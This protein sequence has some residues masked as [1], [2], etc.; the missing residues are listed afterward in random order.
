MTPR[1][2]LTPKARAALLERQGN[3]CACC[4]DPLAL[5]KAQ[6][7]HMAPLWA[8]ADNG[9]DN[10]QLLCGGCHARKTRAE[11]AARGKTKRLENARL[12][13]RKVAASKMQS[14]GFD[15]RLRRL[16]SGKVEVR[17]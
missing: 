12:N 9:T 11:A 1:R 13:G 10:F 14:R 6:A 8:T 17:T 2:H 15:T 3:A 4:H 5:N 7:D 16:M